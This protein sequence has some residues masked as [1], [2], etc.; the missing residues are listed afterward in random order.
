LVC[1]TEIPLLLLLLFKKKKPILYTDQIVEHPWCTLDKAKEKLPGVPIVVMS[2]RRGDD[3]KGKRS[4]S[5][6]K[7]EASLMKLRAGKLYLAPVAVTSSSPSSTPQQPQQPQQPPKSQAPG[8]VKEPRGRDSK[9]KRR[10][11]GDKQA[12]VLRRQASNISSDEHSPVPSPFATI[13]EENEDEDEDFAPRSNSAAGGA[14]GGG[15]SSST[16]SSPANSSAHLPI[17]LVSTDSSGS[18]NGGG[19]E[20]DRPRRDSSASE[21][22]DSDARDSEVRSII[23]HE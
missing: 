14:G 6:T 20:K 13:T 7:I 15:G 5:D 22:R 12:R 9:R 23:N 18:L 4:I 2:R 3:P 10:V 19:S 16:Q 1:I 11:S 21:A 17:L 8:S